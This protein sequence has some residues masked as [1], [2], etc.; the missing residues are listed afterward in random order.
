MDALCITF[1]VREIGGAVSGGTIERVE[2][3]GSDAIAIAIAGAAERLVLDAGTVAPRIGWERGPRGG[4][5]GARADAAGAVAAAA[6]PLIGR[7]IERLE[8]PDGDRWAHVRVEGGWR[9]AWENFGRRANILIVEGETIAACLRTYVRGAP[10]VTRPIVAGGGY[11]PPPPRERAPGREPELGGARAAEGARPSPCIVHAPPPAPHPP[12]LLAFAPDEAALARAGLAGARVERFPTFAAASAAWGAAMAG[13]AAR[14]ALL[15]A[16]R[17]R[18]RGAAR[19]AERALAAVERDLERARRAPEYRRFGEALLAQFRLVA[20]GASEARVADPHDPSRTLAIPLDPMK[21]PQDNADRYFKD[22]KRGERGEPLLVARRARLLEEHARAASENARWSSPD[23]DATP[24][25]TLIEAAEAAGLEAQ[26]ASALRVARAGDLARR[27][28]SGA[29]DEHQAPFAARERAPGRGGERQD[30]PGRQ[31]RKPRDPYF[32]AR[33][34]R[35]EVTGGFT[36]L[37][38]RSDEDNDVLTHKIARPWD[39]WFHSGQTSGSHVVLVKG[40]AKAAP[41]KEALLEAAALAAHH[42]K[43]RKAGLVPV[44]YT[45]KRHVRKPRRAPAGTASCA[46]EKTLFVRPDALS[47]KRVPSRE[48]ADSDA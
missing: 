28:A 35:Y 3:A 41:P 25:D 48:P 11:P 32:G 30:P 46:R 40:N 19:R 5:A 8:Q 20:R 14:E 12:R 15:A 1:L 27:A 33:L 22:A 18:W 24:L 23:A 21:S 38:G 44:I 26:A 7:K 17:A 10:G 2:S 29:G 13:R 39:L 9:I 42:S 36:V 4:R 47:A 34:Y 16:L 45:E 6:A 43:A 31:S 37:V